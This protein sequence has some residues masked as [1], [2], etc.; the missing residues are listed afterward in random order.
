M[1]PQTAVRN[2]NLVALTVERQSSLEHFTKRKIRSF[3]VKGF[4][5]EEAESFIESRVHL[6][7]L[8]R[9][10]FNAPVVDEVVRIT[11]GSPLYMDDLLRLTRIVDVKKALDTWAERRGDEARKYALQREMERLS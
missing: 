2:S 6:Y 3:V 9:Q 4:E 1:S 11:D 8:D 5:K 7:G 10:Q